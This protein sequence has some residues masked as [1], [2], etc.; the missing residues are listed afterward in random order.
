[1]KYIHLKWKW[2]FS[3]Y[4]K[5][6]SLVIQRMLDHITSRLIMHVHTLYIVHGHIYICMIYVIKNIYIYIYIYIYD[7]KLLYHGRN[8]RTRQCPLCPSHLHVKHNPGF[9]LGIH[10]ICGVACCWRARET[11]PGELWFLRQPPPYQL[12]TFSQIISKI[13]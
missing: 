13:N 8:P 5:E 1:M 2:L 12:E 6:E 7:L 9:C 10:W 4:V 3:S 11:F